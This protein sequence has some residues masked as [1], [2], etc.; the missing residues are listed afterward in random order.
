MTADPAPASAFLVGILLF[1]PGVTFLAAVQVIATAQADVALT[2]LGVT[3]VVVINVLL[4]WLP[5]LFYALAPGQT[6]HHLTAFN[7]WLR[8]HG[9]VL[10]VSLLLVVGGIMVAN[11]LYGLA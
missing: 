9:R 4:V 8:A 2:I 5:I 6:R 10:V 7:R 11:G 1:A 3:I